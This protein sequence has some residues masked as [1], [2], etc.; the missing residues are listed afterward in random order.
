[1]KYFI[2]LSSLIAV[3]FILILAACEKEETP[4]N[5]NPTPV[6]PYFTFAKVGN[7]AEFE[8]KTP[9]LT[10]TYTGSMTQK[11]LEKLATNIYKIE[12][13][14]NLGIPSTSPIIDTS[15]WYISSTEFANVEDINGTNKFL[16]FAKGDS[17]NKIY[18]NI[19]SVGTTTTRII[20][21]VN[22]PLVTPVGNFSTY[23][24]KETNDKNANESTY[25]IN[26]SVGL[27]KLTRKVTIAVIGDLNVE[28]KLI[29]K[30]Y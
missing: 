28:I 30:N 20:Q 17:I 2:K 6:T 26:N 3:L 23:K 16:Y 9:V 14:I 10:T 19:D 4:V 12:T 15:L 22:E 7:I 18:T 21:S 25:Y 8:T 5:N 1:M 27:V 11:I 13:S 29:S 24:L